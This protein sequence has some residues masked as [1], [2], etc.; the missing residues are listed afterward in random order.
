MRAKKMD[1]KEKVKIFLSNTESA[2]KELKN[3]L[4]KAYLERGEKMRRGEIPFDQRRKKFREAFELIEEGKELDFSYH[5][6]EIPFDQHDENY[7]NSLL[8]IE[9]FHTNFF[10]HK[11]RTDD[12]LEYFKYYHEGGYE[13]FILT[14]FKKL[15]DWFDEKTLDRLIDERENKFSLP[16]ICPFVEAYNTDQ[17]PENYEIA[18]NDNPEVSLFVKELISQIKPKAILD[19]NFQPRS[20]ATYSK[21]IVWEAL[22]H[23]KNLCDSSNIFFD[24]DRI[25][26]SSLQD[27]SL[28]INT[29]ISKKYD[30]IIFNPHPKFHPRIIQLKYLKKG[31]EFLKKDGVLVFCVPSSSIKSRDFLESLVSE[32]LYI[33]A[34]F[35]SDYFF[36]KEEVDHV[37]EMIIPTSYKCSILIISK[38]SKEKVFLAKVSQRN[39]HSIQTAIKNYLT[40]R[41]TKNK[42]DFGALI[43]IK[44]YRGIDFLS[45]THKLEKLHKDIHE[46]FPKKIGEISDGIFDFENEEELILNPTIPKPNIKTLSN[47]D[48]LEKYNSI[49][50]SKYH[51]KKDFV[52]SLIDNPIEKEAQI[53]M[54]KKF[55]N[56]FFIILKEEYNSIFFENYFNSKV[57]K[58]ILSINRTSGI[59]FKTLSI[60]DLRDM[61]VYVPNSKD[62]NRI[63]SS[64]NSIEDQLNYFEEFKR[65]IL[66]PNGMSDERLSK[67]IESIEERIDSLETWIDTLPFPLGSI[68]GRYVSTVEK[69][70]KVDHL[71]GFFESYSIFI[72]TIILSALSNNRDFYNKHKKHW[73]EST[74]D[75][76]IRQSSFGNWNKFYNDLR[77]FLKDKLDSGKEEEK[78]I[79]FEL[80][81]TDDTQF[82]EFITNG[83]IIRILKKANDI[84]NQKKSHGGLIENKLDNV[85]QELQTLLN[86]FKK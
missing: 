2:K 31:K 32:G 11:K 35:D 49:F 85:L 37:S 29:N 57:G 72:S 55:N 27:N 81:A 71:L 6:A 39:L 1:L 73:R 41:L 67:K 74:K 59:E 14:L 70:E 4:E 16:L 48:D 84:R 13:D 20:L 63:V 66:T 76:W 69:R 75:S 21:D 77:N 19:L 38:K 79:I 7:I 15:V 25:I 34:I 47:G 30:F 9:C 26:Y 17:G 56:Y 78:Q 3:S 22:C 36:C 58:E 86:K 61:I 83:V 65:K 64:I 28:V 50:I 5:L 68:L 40:D 43:E 80:F 51:I 33:S 8:K 18:G 54:P 23:D 12:F 45:S 24:S 10:I 82:F 46:L 53:N 44:K 42:L 60:E 52:E 62:Q